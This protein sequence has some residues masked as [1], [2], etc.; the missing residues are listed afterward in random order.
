MSDQTKARECEKKRDELANEYA[1]IRMKSGELV[2][3]QRYNDYR[4][5]YDAGFDAMK[6]ERDR[7]KAAL[8]RIANGPDQGE[9]DDILFLRDLA[10]QALEGSHE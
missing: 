5:G 6:A 7:Y 10:H 4:A 3:I 1:N 2:N 9:H 8:G